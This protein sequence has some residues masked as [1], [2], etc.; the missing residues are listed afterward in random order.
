MAHF[1]RCPRVRYDAAVLARVVV[2][3]LALAGC[4][5]PRPAPP[6]S[7]P[8]PLAVVAD[9]PRAPIATEEARTG[10]RAPIDAPLAVAV[11]AGPPPRARADRIELTFTGDIMFGGTFSGRWRPQEAGTF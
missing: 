4:G 5:S 6:P 7:V 3:V 10:T 11:D 2:V 8:E 1:S 9:A